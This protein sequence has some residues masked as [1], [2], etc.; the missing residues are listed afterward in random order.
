[1]KI[2]KILAVVVTL[3]LV[4][5]TVSVMAQGAPPPPPPGGSTSGP[6]DSGVVTLLIGAATYGYKKLKERETAELE[7]SE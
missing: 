3:I 7:V 6:I 2:Q 1:M 5:A 4:S